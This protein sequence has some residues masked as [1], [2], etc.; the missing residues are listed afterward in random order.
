MISP[1][2]SI[3]ANTRARIILW[4]ATYYTMVCGMCGDGCGRC[5]TMLVLSL[6]L[7]LGLFSNRIHNQIVYILKTCDKPLLNCFRCL[8]IQFLQI[9]E[10]KYKKK[11]HEEKLKIVKDTNLVKDKMFR[12]IKNTKTITSNI[13]AKQYAS[14]GKI[15]HAA[16]GRLQFKRFSIAYVR[17]DCA[18]TLQLQLYKTSIG[19]CWFQKESHRVACSNDFTHTH[20]MHAISVE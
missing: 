16:N 7:F 10:S 6:S 13:S 18:I 12:R 8:S 17:I 1:P 2:L 19:K 4:W 3:F 9:W 15:Y 20:A 5:A 11:K 14:N